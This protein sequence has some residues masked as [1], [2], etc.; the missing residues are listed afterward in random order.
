MTTELVATNDTRG[1]SWGSKPELV[2]WTKTYSQGPDD[3]IRDDQTLV[4][5]QEDAG[6]GPYWILKTEHWAFCSIADMVKLLRAAGVDET[7]DEPGKDD[8]A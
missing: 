5:E 8:V 6:A 1:P 7:A 2:G 4:I 3:S